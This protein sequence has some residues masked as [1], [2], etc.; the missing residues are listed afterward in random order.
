M[1]IYTKMSQIIKIEMHVTL[2]HG[3]KNTCI[4]QDMFQM[5]FNFFSMCNNKE[6][7]Y[8]DL[9]KQIN[10]RQIEDNLFFLFSMF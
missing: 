5:Y 10:F 8:H 3:N 7:K 9:L 6:E 2:A 4:A 1:N